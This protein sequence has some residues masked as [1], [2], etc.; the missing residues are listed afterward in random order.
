[1]SKLPIRCDTKRR[2]LGGRKLEKG[3]H[4]K[5]GEQKAFIGLDQSL[6]DQ[7]RGTTRK[8]GGK[9]KHFQGVTYPIKAF[10]GNAIK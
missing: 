8:K 3:H 1:M 9:K 5:G 6:K 7:K 10:T 4:R 2:K